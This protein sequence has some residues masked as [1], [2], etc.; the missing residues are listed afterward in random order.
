MEKKGNRVH[1]L[2]IRLTQEE[3]DR[4][5]ETVEELKID[6][7]ELVRKLLFKGENTLMVTSRDFRQ[8]TDKIGPELGKIGSNV[9]QFARYVNTLSKTNQVKP[10]LIE[11]FNNLLLEYKLANDELISIFNTLMKSKKI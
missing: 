3:H 5:S 8:A 10:E 2:E 11:D 1:R 7:S 4:L 6:K 9:N